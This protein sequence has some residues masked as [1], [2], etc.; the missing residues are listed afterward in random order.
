MATPFR[1]KLYLWRSSQRGIKSRVLDEVS[2]PVLQRNDI[3][4]VQ[5]SNKVKRGSRLQKLRLYFYPS[6]DVDKSKLYAGEMSGSLD[7]AKEKLFDMGFRNNPTAYVEVTDEHGPDDGSY[8]LH[9][10]SED[11]TRKDIPRITSQPTIWKRT[12]LQFHVAVYEL[13]DRVIFLC[14]KEISA[15]LQPA[16]H[17]WKN[18]VSARIGVRDFRDRWF[19]EFEQ[20]LDGK[21]KVKWETMH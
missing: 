13:L 18:D 1:N 2:A 6:I 7:D 20:E 19:D 14:H 9:Q 3:P 11:G 21:Q 4:D 15:W 17:V 16:R 12:K 8:S 10:I 5:V